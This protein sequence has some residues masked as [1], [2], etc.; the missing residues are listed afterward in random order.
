MVL[1]ILNSYMQKNQTDNFLIPYTKNKL[2]IK[3]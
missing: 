3:T 2:K 1:E